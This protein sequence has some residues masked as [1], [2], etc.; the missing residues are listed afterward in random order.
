VQL[1]KLLL[2][3]CIVPCALPLPL[4][5]LSAKVFVESWKALCRWRLHL[6]DV[7]DSYNES[8]FKRNLPVRSLSLVSP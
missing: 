8:I 3:I 5:H 6:R 2:C 7:D 4:Y 1:G